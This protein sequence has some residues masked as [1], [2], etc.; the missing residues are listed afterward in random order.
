MSH[1]QTFGLE[2][3]IFTANAANELREGNRTFGAIGVGRE[4]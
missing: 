1:F 2:V 3:I 4:K